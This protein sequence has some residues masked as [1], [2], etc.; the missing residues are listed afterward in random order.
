MVNLL[1][2]RW[3]AASSRAPAF[4][5]GLGLGAALAMAF[6]AL[7]EES[8]T[9]ETAITSLLYAIAQLAI[10]TEANASRIVAIEER[11]DNLEEALQE[12]S[13]SGR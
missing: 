1:A 5:C 7:T 11:V 12:F 9:R 8:E 6:P 2:G 13:A 10:D 3:K 4:I